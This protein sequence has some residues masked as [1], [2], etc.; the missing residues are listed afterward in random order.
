M[1]N[2]EKSDMINVTIVHS[3]RNVIIKKMSIME[4]N[5][6]TTWFSIYFPIL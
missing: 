1:S 5:F 6:K 3:L 2:D 4:N